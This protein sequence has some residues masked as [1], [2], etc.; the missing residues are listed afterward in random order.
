MI[1]QEEV[2]L[3]EGFVSLEEHDSSIIIDLR[4]AGADNFTGAPV[5]G[6][7]ADRCLLTTQAAS[8][9]S[10][11][12]SDLRQ[13]GYGPKV[14][15]A[16]RPQRAVDHFVNWTKDPQDPVLKARFFPD[17]AK[18]KLTEDGYIAAKSGHS[19][20]STVDLTIVKFTDDDAPDGAKS[21]ELDMGTPLDFF[22]LRFHSESRL[23]NTGQRL[24]RL[25][26]RTPMEKH[27]FVHLP[28]E[29]WH[30]S[31]KEKP[32]PDT[33]FGFPIR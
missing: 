17:V 28:E 5:T 26:L 14:F 32:F 6:Y 20:G 24:H 29:W 7:T 18:Y 23:V 11:V 30:F 22:S 9:L 33:Y 2:A 16:Y 21:V 10:N 1:A 8:A 3:P 27:G 19:R 4:Y 13:F 15:D 25:L 31:L 12:R